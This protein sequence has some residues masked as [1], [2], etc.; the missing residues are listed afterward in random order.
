MKNGFKNSLS[1][2]MPLFYIE[3]GRLANECLEKQQQ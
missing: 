3:V 2:F 1:I